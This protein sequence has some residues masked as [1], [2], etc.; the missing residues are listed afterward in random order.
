[1]YQFP[2]TFARYV[3]YLLVLTFPYILTLKQNKTPYL[4]GWFFGIALLIGTKSYGGTV[5]FFIALLALLISLPSQIYRSFKYVAIGGLVIIAL[6][7]SL[8]APKLPKWQTTI[9]D[10][11]ASRLEYWHIAFGVIHDHF[12]TGIGIKTWETDY[13]DLLKKYGPLAQNKLPLNWSSP[14][15]HDVFLDSFVKAGFPGF[16]AITALMLWPAVI[17]YQLVRQYEKKDAYW[18]FGVSMIAYSVAM[19]VFGIADD[20]LWSDDTMPLLFILYFS[21]AAVV[22][23]TENMRA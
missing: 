8:N 22:N 19:I 20:P 1:L 4:V 12:W 5:A 3:A 21:L 13:I 11:R 17:G 23:Q 14:Q 2:N 6:L 15:P 18:W 10:S 16:I 9:N 7:V